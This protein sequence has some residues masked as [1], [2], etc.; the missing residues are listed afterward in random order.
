[1]CNNTQAIVNHK[2][3]M[4][5]KDKLSNWKTLLDTITTNIDI[6]QCIK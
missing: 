4:I 6:V 1:M 5:L 2:I 3:I